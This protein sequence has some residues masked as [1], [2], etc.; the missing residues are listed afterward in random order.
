MISWHILSL[1]IFFVE[2]VVLPS[3]FGREFSSENFS[4]EIFGQILD[5]FSR[6]IF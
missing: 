1:Q 4:A 3:L 2:Y 6:D 5:V